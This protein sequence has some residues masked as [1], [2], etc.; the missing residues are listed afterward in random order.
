MASPP[1]GFSV[2]VVSAELSIRQTRVLLLEEAG[3][4]PQV[5]ESCAGAKE[6]LQLAKF[7]LV[8]LDHTFSKDD[9]IDFIQSMRKMR[10]IT[11]VLLLHKSAADCG[12]DLHLDSREGPDALIAALDSILKRPSA[13]APAAIIRPQSQDKT[14]RA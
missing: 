1:N 9:R 12:A 10:S 2:L 6:A 13:T 4:T 7:D 5:A 14:N 8:I 11:R 3:H